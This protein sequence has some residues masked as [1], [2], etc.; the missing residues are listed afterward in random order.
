M[1]HALFWLFTSCRKIGKA[2]GSA[3]YEA[4][5]VHDGVEHAGYLAYLSMLALFPFLVLIVFV[6]GTLGEGHVGSEFI[7]SMFA[8]LPQHAVDALRPRIEEISVNP[9][10]GLV[11]FSIIGAIWTASSAVEGLRTVLNR[12]YH[13]STPPAYIFRRLLSV[14]QLLFFA[15]LLVIGMMVLVFVPIVTHKVEAWLGVHFLSQAFYDVQRVLY[16]FSALIMLCVVAYLYYILPNI[17]QRLIDVVPGAIVTLM[18]WVIAA[19]AYTAYLSSF[20]Q[21]NLIYGSLGGIIASLIF[22]FIINLCFIIGAEFNYQFA[23]AFGLRLEEKQQS[24]DK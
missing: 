22:F 9:P 10:N 13:V 1:I 19:R 4:V 15:A 2:L 21:V 5:V 12:A 17:R 6:L 24:E 20:N 7:Q 3:A 16:S 8:S 11:T 23:E 18:L 14:A